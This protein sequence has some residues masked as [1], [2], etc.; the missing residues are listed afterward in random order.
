MSVASHVQIPNP[1]SDSVINAQYLDSSLEI[2][3]LNQ[4]LNPAYNCLIMHQIRSYDNL[5]FVAYGFTLCRIGINLKTYRQW[6]NTEQAIKKKPGITVT[7]LLI[8]LLVLAFRP[9]WP[10][11]L[12]A[13]LVLF[14]DCL[15]LILFEPIRSKHIPNVGVAYTAFDV[16]IE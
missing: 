15:N 12:Y 14:V 9:T 11:S 3:N 1:V 5:N 10:R 6:I 2:A 16:N 7:V 13:W 4:F 8:W